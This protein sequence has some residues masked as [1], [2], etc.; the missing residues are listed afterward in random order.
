MDSTRVGLATQPA[1]DPQA[2]PAPA[3][4]RTGA[5]IDVRTRWLLVWAILGALAI[6]GIAQ[7]V[8]RTFDVSVPS[9]LLTIVLYLPLAAWVW[10]LVARRARVDL[11]V[12]FRWPRLGAYWWIVAG[13]LVVQLVFSLGA[14]TLTQVAFPGLGDSLEDVGQGNLVIAVIAIGI[15]P[16]LVEETVFRGVLLERY[17]VKWRLGVGVLVSALF[18][19]ILHVDPVGA[20]MFGVI[21]GLLYLRTRSLW[22]GILIHAAN[23]L[24][25]LIAQRSVD[26]GADVPEATLTDSLITAGVLL[27]IS[28]PL[29]AWYIRHN[30]PSRSAPTPYQRHEIRT[31]LPSRTVADVRWSAVPG[32]VQVEVSATSAQ[33]ADPAGTPLAVLPLARV[34]AVYPT[35]TP[36]GLSVVVLLHDGSWTTLQP[37][38]N[39]TR[40]KVLA[41]TLAERVQYRPRPAVPT[42]QG[43]RLSP[44]AP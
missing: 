18:F 4:P 35:D 20:G 8:E 13:L 15:M 5:F 26:P 23:N 39:S 36:E 16:P 41:L 10:L 34:R 2:A 22:P 40:A 32:P 14:I 42:P 11:R 12:L 38:G 7:A 43:T 31:G 6:T 37:A 33:V 28:V 27:L 29:L 1:P 24:I 17:A 3:P 30:W 21:T 25:V 19:G 44:P 9:D